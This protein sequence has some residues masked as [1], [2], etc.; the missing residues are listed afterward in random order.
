[1][2]ACAEPPNKYVLLQYVTGVVMKL[3]KKERLSF[4][5]Q[6]LILEAL[7][8][9]EAESYAK[10]RIALQEGYTYHYDWMV[11][12]LY[13]ELSEEQCR[14]VIDILDMYSEIAWGLEKLDE[15]DELKKHHRARFPGFDGNHETHL[16]AYVRYFVVDLDRFSNLKRDEYPYFN[17]HCPMLDT[18]RKMLERWRAFDSR[19][20]LN[21][22]KI[23]ALLEA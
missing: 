22:E 1:M 20:Q 6:L 19:H 8:P 23:A 18:Y 17:S 13:D 4:I 11:E 9:D 10:D 12:H 7:Y 2:P 15:G 16:M 21:R 14:E 3:T 5:N